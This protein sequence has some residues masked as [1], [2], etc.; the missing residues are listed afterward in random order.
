LIVAALTACTAAGRGLRG[1]EPRPLSALKTAVLAYED[2]GRKLRFVE[3]SLARLQADAGLGG[4][5]EVARGTYADLFH[6]L[7]TGAV[8]LAVVTPALLATAL[9]RRGF[10]RWEYLASVIPPSAPSPSLSVAIVRDDSSLRTIEDLRALAARG[11]GRLFFV[12]PLSVSGALAPRAALAEVKI[13]IPERRVR[14]THSHSNSLRALRS[15]ENR[16]AVAFVW[17]GILDREATAGTRALELPGLAKRMIPPD[18]L[19]ARADLPALGRLRKAIGTSALPGAAPVFTTDPAWRDTCSQVQ[20]LLA[21]A[22][23]VSPERLT[24]LDLDELGGLLLHY[25]RSQTAPLRLAVVFS[26]GGAKCSYQ[27]GAIRAIEEK[28]A[29]LRQQTGDPALDIGLVV[30]TSGGAI[31]A[32]PVAMGMSSSPALYQEI[33]RSWH[34]LD[35]RNI[36]RPA[37]VVRLNLALWFAAVQFLCLWWIWRLGARDPG[38]SRLGLWLLCLF[39]GATEVVAAR[40]PLDPWSLLGAR[41]GAHRFYLWLSFGIEG[42][43]WI[44]AATGALGLALRAT[45]VGGRPAFVLFRRILRLAAFAGIIVLPLLQAW[46]ILNHQPTLSE[47]FGIEETLFDRFS[48]LLAAKRHADGR[49][50]APLPSADGENGRAASREAMS[51]QIIRDGLISRDLVLTGSVLGEPGLELPSDLYFWLSAGKTREPPHFGARGISLAE[52]PQL[53]LDALL[54]SGAIYPVFPARVLHDFPHAGQKT[55]VVDGSFSHRSPVEAAVLW[56]ATHIILIQADPDE[57]VPRGTFSA[58]IAAALAHLYEQAQLTDLRTKEQAMIFSLTPRPPHIGL[59]DF[60]SNLIDSSIAKGYREAH[61]ESG[62]SALASAPF[63][64]EVGVPHFVVASG[65]GRDAR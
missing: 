60:A 27:V 6:W 10:P 61:G 8:D 29:E 20:A 4:P 56:G 15:A 39:V 26:G 59:L 34:S 48:G 16:D 57:M 24:R 33:T 63:R 21:A 19:I 44:L 62:G 55:E 40:V 30:G 13:A 46:T 1:D 58:N 5:L 11:Q 64:K 32:L 54:A 45:G 9:Q 36:I 28:L 22:G 47:G 14:Y 49:T 51:S 50:A 23:P 17:N 31:N 25:A 37:F 3:L 43:G 41:P 53:L 2:Q 42:C 18:A 12:D 52:R 38:S 7:E 65:S 35:Q